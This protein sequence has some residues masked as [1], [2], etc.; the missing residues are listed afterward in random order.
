MRPLPS[1]LK[2]KA[3][4]L[5]AREIKLSSPVVKSSI[6]PAPKLVV[7]SMRYMSLYF[8]VNTWLIKPS[9]R[10]AVAYSRFPDR[11]GAR[12]HPLVYLYKA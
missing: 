9:I 11:I 2:K 7:T 8:G 10:L 4:S 5:V 12:K 1:S 6:F 3:P